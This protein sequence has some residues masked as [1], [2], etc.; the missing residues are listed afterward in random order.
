[1]QGRGGVVLPLLCA[2]IMANAM[3]CKAGKASAPSGQGGEGRKERAER[4]VRAMGLNS[5][6]ML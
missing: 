5:L 3:W 6:S 4:R 1:M 2:Y